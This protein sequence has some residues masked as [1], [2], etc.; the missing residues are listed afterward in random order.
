[1][2]GKEGREGEAL[3]HYRSL[4]KG[5]RPERI[6]GLPK[7]RPTEPAKPRNK[8]MDRETAEGKMRSLGEAKGEERAG[9]KKTMERE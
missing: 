7:G 1:M 3:G 5:T 8:R 4:N 2:I 6:F 9:G